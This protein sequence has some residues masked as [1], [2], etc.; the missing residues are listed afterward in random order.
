MKITGTFRILY[1]NI[2]VLTITKY[3][4]LL[5]MLKH[6]LLLSW[7][8]TCFVLICIFFLLCLVLQ[9]IKRNFSLTTLICPFEY[10]LY[11]F[12]IYIFDV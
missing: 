1:W 12:D 4:S 7:F 3:V 8:V 6:V 9:I 10:H 11:I 5:Y 2:I